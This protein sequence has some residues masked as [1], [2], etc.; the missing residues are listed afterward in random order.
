MHRLIYIIALFTA[1]ALVS[2]GPKGP[3]KPKGMLDS[4]NA[5]LAE[6][7]TNAPVLHQRAKF[8]LTQKKYP[9]ALK[10]MVRV[11]D[12]DST[13]APYFVT[14]ADLYLVMNKSGKAKSALEKSVSIEPNN[15]EAILKL[16]EL[17]LYVEDYQK[18]LDYSNMALKIDMRLARGYFTKGMAYLYI[19]DTARAK[20]NFN[21]T[22]EQDPDYLVAYEN[23]GRI[24]AVHNEPL[25]EVYF[26]N[27]LNINPQDVNVRYLLGEYYQRNERFDDAMREYTNITRIMPTNRSAHYNMGYI[28]FVYTLDYNTAIKY[29]SDAIAADPKYFEAFYMRGLCYEKLGNI[30]SA[31]ADFKM[32]LQ[33]NANFDK[34][35]D[36]LKRLGK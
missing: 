14:M 36:G 15:T 4:L 28:N 17:Y 32:A 13:K 30:P 10:D 11:L 8:F 21:T 23:L 1:F 25:T 9:E 33:F 31:E 3:S 20:A 34:A 5:I 24:A 26:K 27:A 19:G 12:I 18:A 29:F 2:C 35:K 6:D 7:S 22:V 16:A